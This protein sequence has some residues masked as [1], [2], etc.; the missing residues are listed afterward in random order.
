MGLQAIISF[1]FIACNKVERRDNL[2]ESRSENEMIF[3]HI[4]L[5][6]N[7]ALSMQLHGREIITSFTVLFSAWAEAR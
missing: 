6:K 3:D 2:L 5:E 7:L 1:F 4:G